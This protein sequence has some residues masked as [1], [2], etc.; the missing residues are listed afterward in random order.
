VSNKSAL[1]KQASEIGKKHPPIKDALDIH[2]KFSEARSQ[3]TMWSEG[4]ET[5]LSSADDADTRRKRIKLHDNIA[6]VFEQSKRSEAVATDNLVTE[7]GITADW[8]PFAKNYHDAEVWVTY[9]ITKSDETQKLTDEWKLWHHL[10]EKGVQRT[11]TDHA[12]LT[13][14][15]SEWWTSNE[16]AQFGRR[17]LYAQGQM[18][19]H[20][21]RL[22]DTI[23]TGSEDGAWSKGSENAFLTHLS[24]LDYADQVVVVGVLVRGLRDSYFGQKFLRDQFAHT[25]AYAGYK[26][27]S[28]GTYQMN[29]KHPN[30]TKDG[31]MKGTDVPYPRAFDPIELFN[32]PVESDASDSGKAKNKGIPVGEGVFSVDSFGDYGGYFDPNTLTFACLNVGRVA[33]GSQRRHIT[34]RAGGWSGLVG[35]TLGAVGSQFLS[36]PRMQRWP[37]LSEEFKK[38]YLLLNRLVAQRSSPNAT[39]GVGPYSH[40]SALSS[41]GSDP[42]PFQN[43]QQ[44]DLDSLQKRNWADEMA[45]VVSIKSKLL[46]QIL[47]G[48]ADFADSQ[49]NKGRVAAFSMAEG[50]VGM[51]M[52]T[53]LIIEGDAKLGEVRRFFES[54]AN[55]LDGLSKFVEY[56]YA[57][58]AEQFG[59]GAA[60]SIGTKFWSKMGLGARAFGHVVGTAVDLQ[61]TYQAYAKA[62]RGDMDTAALYGI[63]ALSGSAMTYVVVTGLFSWPVAVG[64]GVISVGSYITG[65]LIADSAM[66]GW[67]GGTEFGEHHG[68]CKPYPPRS[69]VSKGILGDF[70]RWWIDGF[71]FQET[72]DRQFAAFNDL[73][74]KSERIRVNA[75]NKTTVEDVRGKFTNF[76]V[77]NVSSGDH[78]GHVKIETMEK[79]DAAKGRFYLRSWYTPAPEI[80]DPSHELLHCIHLTKSDDRSVSPGY[81]GSLSYE[82]L[83][84][85]SA[86]GSYNYTYHLFIIDGTN[87]KEKAFEH[88]FDVPEWGSESDLAIEAVWVPSDRAGEIEDLRTKGKDMGGWFQ[89]VEH[90][91]EKFPQLPRHTMY[92]S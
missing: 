37:T 51:T 17:K 48:F 66:V 11:A 22:I 15:G 36:A 64:L 65:S 70:E 68:S 32:P 8:N 43:A 84:A 50:V 16:W 86:T 44:V 33:S 29:G 35:S 19:Y 92:L 87:E 49:G 60:K 53:V 18:E 27:T 7:L 41:Q 30:Q 10:F 21:K 23:T 4:D 31:E 2:A 74:R 69:N 6:M 78:V 40:F 80:T 12:L 63:S 14:T 88:I 42:A 20:A 39:Y 38:E 57:A 85:N 58:V 54:L 73:T 24:S 67:V 59:Q 25:D 62:S 45:Q 81:S 56:R 28:D 26:R 52:T 79:L 47:S 3:Y 82:V 89:T 77:S 5:Y 55:F 34:G 1:K 83:V 76:S 72:I 61:T 90:P 71:R 9:G 75:L 13:G 46:R 91:T